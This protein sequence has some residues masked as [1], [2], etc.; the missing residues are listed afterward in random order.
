MSDGPRLTRR[1]GDLLALLFGA[2]M[3]A[4]ASAR[5]IL[6]PI[7]HDEAFTFLHWSTASWRAILTFEGPERANNHL[8]NTILMKVSAALLGPGEAA[9]R[10]PNVLALASY[11]ASL[12]L[13]LR[14]RAPPVLALSGFVLASANRH[15][16]E[17]FS[18]ARGY[19]L[20]LGFLLPGLLFA[21]HSI[22]E[23]GGSRRNEWRSLGLVSLAVQFGKGIV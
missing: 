23:T 18:L 11:L 16:L 3:L 15:L 4:F 7:T 14:R 12:W 17:L 2:A 13:L 22:E 21:A 10:L 6:V 19:G 20:C 1:R 9:L 8:L 5:A